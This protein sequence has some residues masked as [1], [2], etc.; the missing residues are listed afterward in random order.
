MND[1]VLRNAGRIIGV[2]TLIALI[3]VAATIWV[4]TRETGLEAKT[5]GIGKAGPCRAAMVDAREAGHPAPFEAAIDDE[6]CRLQSRL[7][8]ASCLDHHDCLDI[9]DQRLAQGPTGPDEEGGGASGSGGNPPGGQ[10]GPGEGPTP[11]NPPGPNPPGPA[12]RNLLD[13]VDEAIE[14]TCSTAGVDCSLVPD[15]SETVPL[16]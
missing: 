15:A 14:E 7:L 9:I 12:P 2:L 8:I 11:G 16:P 3:L 13:E 6:E 4:I 5:Q 1:W 10:P